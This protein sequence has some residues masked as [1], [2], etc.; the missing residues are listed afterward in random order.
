[1]PDADAPFL[2]RRP[3]LADLPAARRIHCDPRTNAFRPGGAPTPQE[4]EGTL[5]LWLEH[6]DAHGF[7]YWAVERQEDGAVVGFGGVMHAQHGPHVGLNLYFR[8]GPEVWSQGLARLIGRAAL[9]EAFVR[10]ELP[11]VLG[12]VRPANLPSR[13]ALERL[14]L[15]AFDTLDDV[16]GEAL[17]LLYRIDRGDTRRATPCP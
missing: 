15:R 9:E 8:L 17:S 7:G 4:V 11:C 16:P 14:G 2:L 6:W 5:L 12:L 3:T 10:R 1:M 13:R